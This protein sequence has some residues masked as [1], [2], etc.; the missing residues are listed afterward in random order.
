M[1]DIEL[2]QNACRVKSRFNEIIYELSGNQS[3]SIENLS[4]LKLLYNNHNCELYDS[5]LT[6]KNGDIISYNSSLYTSKSDD[7]TNNKPFEGSDFWEITKTNTCQIGS[8]YA[9]AGCNFQIAY[10]GLYLRNNHN[11]AFVE[12]IKEGLVKFNFNTTLNLS[13]NDYQVYTE[14]ADNNLLVRYKDKNFIVFQIVDY[15]DGYWL[16]TD[17]GFTIVPKQY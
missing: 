6:Y 17:Y 4:D 10:D 11:I 15:G 5:N 8:I 12:I 9:A 14:S 16:D 1:T 2:M 3:D 7:N 13:D